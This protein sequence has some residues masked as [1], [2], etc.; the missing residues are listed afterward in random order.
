MGSKGIANNYDKQKLG[1]FNFVNFFGFLSGIVIPLLGLTNNT[2][3]PTIAWVV[4]ISPCFISGAVL[5]AIYLQ[6][7][8]AALLTYFILYPTLTLAVYVAGIDVGIELFF[9]LYGVFSI[10]FLQKINHITITISYII[11]CYIST[12]FIHLHYDVVLKNINMPF[13]LF[14]QFLSIAFI[15]VGL[16]FIKKENTIYQNTINNNLLVLANNNIE[17]VQKSK[18]LETTTLQLQELNEIKNRL[19]SIIGHDLRT[20]MY[21]LKNLFK[22][23]EQHNLP[24][25]EIKLLIPAIVDDLNYATNLME[26]L[27]QWGKSQMEGSKASMQLLNINEL[28]TSTQSLMR[29]QADNKKVHLLTKINKPIY[30]Y[31]DKDMIDLVLRNLMS[32]AIKYTHENGEVIVEATVQNEIVQVTVQDNGMGIKQEN[33]MNLFGDEYFTTK[34][35]NNESGTGLGLKLCKDFV[36]KNGGTIQVTSELGKGSTFSFT[37]P[38]A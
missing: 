27:L 12:F 35:T 25:T 24:A 1:I 30:I 17:I 18:A 21:G 16:F 33:L 9:V 20:P 32:N 14:N 10:F 36:H 2:N 19:F 7:Y 37:L 6:K 4:A 31:A 15:F 5:I 23:I 26:N 13:Y 34:G 28:I 3:L 29:L 8:N 11:L 38:K 22:S